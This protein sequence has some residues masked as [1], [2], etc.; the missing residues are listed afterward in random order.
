M[1]QLITTI[2][3]L[4]QKDLQA[5]LD[6]YNVNNVDDFITFLYNLD[7]DDVQEVMQE[8]EI[9]RQFD[10]VGYKHKKLWKKR[11]L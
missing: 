1:E 11:N 7:E 8:I 6:N 9:N 10:K 5:F 3:E 2:G 4:Y